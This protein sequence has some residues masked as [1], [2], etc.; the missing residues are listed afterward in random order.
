MNRKNRA[1]NAPKV[2]YTC[3]SC[4]KIFVGSKQRSMKRKKYCSM[5]CKRKADSGRSLTKGRTVCNR[6]SWKSQ[7]V[8][9]CEICGFDRVVNRSHIIPVHLDGQHIPENI[10]VL[11]PNHH[12]LFD[13]GKLTEAETA[14]ISNKI[15]I[16]MAVPKKQNK[17]S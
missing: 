12:W 10:V 6:K 4:K 15:A 14:K 5:K 11:C 8:N 16:A 17:V 13:H 3:P 9:Y 1:R 7:F 2:E